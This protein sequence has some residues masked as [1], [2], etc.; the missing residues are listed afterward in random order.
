MAS[1]LALAV[2]YYLYR[3][4]TQHFK[5]RSFW[6]IGSVKKPSKCPIVILTEE[7]FSTC[8]FLGR[9]VWRA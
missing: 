8:E 9:T 2:S 7:E 5:Y 3:A 6:D 1:A 4:S